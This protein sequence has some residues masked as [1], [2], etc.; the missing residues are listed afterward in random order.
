MATATMTRA[1]AHNGLMDHRLQAAAYDPAGEDMDAEGEEDDLEEP[2]A[3]TS[4]NENDDADS[5]SLSELAEDEDGHAEV[6]SEEDGDAAD[7]LEDAVSA[8]ASSTRARRNHTRGRK[9][10]AE[11]SQEEESDIEESG[12]GESSEEEEDVLE[13]DD[14]SADETGESIQVATRNNCV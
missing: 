10:D 7:G 9:V 6:E 12:S 3:A 5:E 2:V 4:E 1:A 14:V 11:L 8:E 13:E